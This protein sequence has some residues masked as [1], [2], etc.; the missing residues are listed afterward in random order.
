MFKFDIRTVLIIIFPPFSQRLVLLN[1]GD[2]YLLPN[3]QVM[4]KPLDTPQLA[5]G[6]K[7][8]PSV[9]GVGKLLYL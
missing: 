4:K 5:A 7:T 6:R 1:I 9:V 2:I 3:T 8:A